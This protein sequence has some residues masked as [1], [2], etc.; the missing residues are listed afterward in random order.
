MKP[1]CTSSLPACRWPL[2]GQRRAPSCS[3]PSLPARR[4]LPSASS[5]ARPAGRSA[6][7]GRAAGRPHRPCPTC[8][9]CAWT[10][11]RQ[12]LR[13]HPRRA[14][15]RSAR[16]AGGAR[17]NPGLA[18]SPAALDAAARAPACA[19][20]A[21]EVLRGTGRNAWWCWALP[22][23]RAYRR[24]ARAAARA[25][26]GRPLRFQPCLYRQRRGQRAPRAACR[27]AT[28]NRRRR[29]RRAPSRVG[30]VDSGVDADHRA[31][32][33]ATVHAL[34]LRRRRRIRT[35]HGTAVAALMVGR[36]ERLPRRRARRRAVRGRY[37]LRQPDRRLG[38]PDRRGA[39]LAGARA[40]GGHQPQPGG[41]AEPG[42]ANA[43]SPPWSRAAIC[44]WR[45]SATTARPHRRC[46]RPAIPGVVG[47]TAVDRRGQPLPEAARGPQVLF[48]A[49]G[50]NMVSANPGEPP[51]R[52]VRGTSFAAP[53]V[54]GLLA[55]RPGR[56]RPRAGARGGGGAGAPGRSGRH[57][58]GR[59]PRLRH[60]RRR[61]AHRSGP[62]ALSPAKK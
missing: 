62:P 58:Q 38:R 36:D 6:P 51:Y 46:T 17:R 54:A 30:L 28:R 21:N 32:R 5:A 29:P 18:S 49:P 61:A 60:R 26:S 12:L 10:P 2:C 44:W 14:G 45:R 41:S 57:D 13:E 16:R 1:S 40:G 7:P 52:P 55:P 31:L 47:V 42:P 8:A 59:Q 15:S 33:D 19:C 48:A 11:V 27:A 56:A 22:A 34:G 20:C 4:G 9:G 50:N 43:W 39:R 25:R 3:L 53:I 23:G 24:A 35:P 37:L